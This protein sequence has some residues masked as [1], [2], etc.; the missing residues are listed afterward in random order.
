METLVRRIWSG[1]FHDIVRDATEL[2]DQDRGQSDA[3]QRI[4][5]GMYFYRGPNLQP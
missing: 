1:A 3:D 5:V 2:S 4:R